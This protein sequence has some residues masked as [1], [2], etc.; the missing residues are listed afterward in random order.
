MADLYDN[1]DGW[2][3]RDGRRWHTEYPYPDG[4]K[5]WRSADKK[6]TQ[7]GN[8][9]GTADRIG[10]A[11]TVYVTEGEKDVLTVEPDGG[12]AVC[13]AMGAGK[14]YMFDWS[15]LKDRDVRVVSD[16][17]GPG[18]EHAETVATQLRSVAKSVQIL[19][20][21]V[22]KDAADHIAAARTSTSSSSRTAT[23]TRP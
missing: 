13:P 2:A 1:R 18:R 10:D 16:K 15:P 3:D 14:A 11:Q 23:T 5:V 20:P 7:R 8:T 4:R 12:V 6:F 22:G 19:Q 17:D 21:A 9:K